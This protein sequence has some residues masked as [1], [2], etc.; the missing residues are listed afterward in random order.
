[1]ATDKFRFWPWW[2]NTKQHVVEW[3]CYEQNVHQR[4]LCCVLS[5]LPSRDRNIPSWHNLMFQD[6]SLDLRSA[7]MQKVKSQTQVPCKFP[8]L[9]ISQPSGPI[10]FL[11]Q[12]N[13]VCQEDTVRA[14]FCPRETVNEGEG[15]CS[16][17]IGSCPGHVMGHVTVTWLLSS[18][19][20]GSWAPRTD[21]ESSGPHPRSRTCSRTSTGRE[22]N[23]ERRRHFVR[24]GTDLGTTRYCVYRRIPCCVPQQGR[25]FSPTRNIPDRLTQRD[26]RL[27]MPTATHIPHP[28]K[29]H[30]YRR[31]IGIHPQMSKRIATGIYGNLGQIPIRL[32]CGY[33]LSKEAWGC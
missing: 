30:L 6:I 9:S 32:Q 15:R 12:G 18:S 27:W 33:P 22:G 3:R 20:C 19:T 25:H 4:T 17:W 7:S 1:M 23:S 11:N 8:A 28:L 21:T 24:L 14:S 5:S 13:L 29:A 16:D 26:G 31:R 10:S 2:R